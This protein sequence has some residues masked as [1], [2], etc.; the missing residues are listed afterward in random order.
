MLKGIGVESA[1]LVVLR[2]ALATDHFEQ[3]GVYL[4][5]T[6]GQLFASRDSGDSWEKIADYL[7][8]ILSVETATIE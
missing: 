7:P 4:G 1:H 2:E 8:R 3:A 5:T 6:T